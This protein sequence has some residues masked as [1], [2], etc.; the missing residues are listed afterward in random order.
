MDIEAKTNQYWIAPSAINITLNA[1]GNPNRIQ[2]SVASGAVVSCYIDGVE[3]LGLDNGRNPKRWTLTISPTYF[4][5]NTAKYVYV[6]IPHTSNVGT[7]AVVV[8]PSEKLDIY[9]KNAEG[10]QVGSTDYY[11][12]WLQAIISSS[13]E[14]GNVNR[15]WTSQ[16]NF[17]SLGTYEDIM[18]MSET[19]WYSYSKV[20]G[21][22]TFLKPIIM[23]AGSYFHNLFLG[24]KE[25]TGVATAATAEDFVD[26]DTL[27]ATPNYINTHYL[28]K[29]AEDIA[30]EKI[31]FA[32]GL[33]I[34]TKELF[35]FDEEGNLSA[36]DAMVS[37]LLTA[38]RAVIGKI[39]SPNFVQGNLDGSGWQI[40]D[41]DENGQSR[42][43]IDNVVVR[44]K[45]IANILEARKYVSLGGNYVYS[46]ASSVIEQVDYYKE[47]KQTYVTTDAI[48]GLT[49]TSY[50]C[51]TSLTLS[52]GEKITLIAQTYISVVNEDKNA[53]LA[54][55]SGILEFT[56]SDMVT[57]YVGSLYQSVDVV[58]KREDDIL[59]GYSFIKV[60]WLLKLVPLM[61]R[62]LFYSSTRLVKIG[63]F[64]MS[65]VC[66]FRCWIKA[67]D[68]T[69][70]TINTWE[71]GMLAR[72]QTLDVAVSPD[73]THGEGATGATEN[74][75][76]WRE[77]IAKGQGSLPIDD[78]YTHSY[79]DLSNE[80]GHFLPN[81]D[82]PGVG[83][84]LVCYGATKKDYANMVIIETIGSDAPAIKELKGV[85][86]Q[87]NS[88]DNTV[89]E[90]P[91]WSLTG[92]RK[93][94]ISPT[95][96][97][98]FYAPHFIIETTSGNEQLYNLRRKG[99]AV[100][101]VTTIPPSTTGILE[102]DLVL[103]TVN[104]QALLFKRVGIV[105]SHQ[106]VEYGDTYQC[107]EDSYLYAATP[108]GWENQGSQIDVASFKVEII[109]DAETAYAQKSGLD[110]TQTGEYVR[111]STENISILTQKVNNGKNLLSGVLTG[112]GWASCAAIPTNNE[113]NPT[114]HNISVDA[115]GDLVR[116]NGDTY[117]ASPVVKLE[118]GQTYTLSFIGGGSFVIYVL[119]ISSGVVTE[120]HSTHK[121][122]GGT[123]TT[124]F[125]S[126][127]N[128]N[129][130]RI[131]IG[132]NVK[133]PQ[134]ETGEVATAFEADS[135]DTSSRIKQTADSIEQKVNETGID[136]ENK[137]VTIKAS[138]FKV[139]DE[140]GSVNLIEGVSASTEYPDGHLTLTNTTVNGALVVHK[141]VTSG[142]ET[143][144][145]YLEISK[146]DTAPYINYEIVRNERN[147]PGGHVKDFQSVQIDG[148]ITNGY[149]VIGASGGI[150]YDE[151]GEEKHRTDYYTHL[152][153]KYL[154]SDG[155][156]N[157]TII[158]TANSQSTPNVGTSGYFDNNDRVGILL[159]ASGT[160]NRIKIA[161]GVYSGYQFVIDF[162]NEVRITDKGAQFYTTDHS[163]NSGW[164][165]GSLG[166]TY[167]VVKANTDTSG[168]NPNGLYLLYYG[169]FLIGTS[170][171]VPLTSGWTKVTDYT[172]EL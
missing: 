167:V 111:S 121:A 30:T 49:G 43:E 15:T 119:D 13:G 148:D 57:V 84:S 138:N 123:M 143:G 29:D 73:G 62:N 65:E 135:S 58:V 8:F 106:P 172:E 66:K 115:N 149:A 38:V 105:W 50:Y 139:T 128:Y 87:D 141:E 98:E 133:N 70:R 161:T 25:L 158:V 130:V 51:P 136:I 7:Q 83:D 23:K 31:G 120:V 110:W 78:G 118:Q 1:L 108:R 69:T 146:N 68:G 42:M 55:G 170:R 124:T 85:G 37:G 155:D 39:S 81:S 12:V 14:Y 102:G 171:S 9:G 21:V 20:S 129:N 56:A 131:F 126:I 59:L 11:Y 151:N 163:G 125:T 164:K 160:N 48:S 41:D 95:S 165:G 140:T 47:N 71:V 101:H 96:G 34:K 90:T 132:T 17:G 147:V 91:N 54:S 162:N 27:V 156:G 19:D 74:K 26:S 142:T 99:E 153:P 145:Y 88:R 86:L 75:L 93:T 168:T 80:T 45:F 16:T 44:M 3:G 157:G 82:R 109:G 52:S 169:G 32:K 79:V 61:A 4:N 24:D 6:A 63:D 103:A 89:N 97:N 76:Y 40:T 166:K 94:M 77:V 134:L 92:K 114:Y 2:A 122:G 10:V 18:D 144:H 36:A 35:G 127:N 72:C 112:T 117:L 5:S 53:V 154:I 104:S 33:W 159:K 116:A 64:D 22:V 152:F 100:R 107:T 28:R 150:L 46:P 113:P 67:D 60:P 137:K